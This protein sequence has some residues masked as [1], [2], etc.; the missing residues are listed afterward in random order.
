MQTHHIPADQ[1]WST[2]GDAQ[3]RGKRF[4]EER[5]RWEARAGRPLAGVLLFS[6]QR[7]RALAEHESAIERPGVLEAMVL[8]GMDVRYVFHGERVLTDA[9]LAIRDAYRL[10]SDDDRLAIRE[11]ASA[12]RIAPALRSDLD[13]LIYAGADTISYRRTSEA[14][15]D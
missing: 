13:D 5:A 9:E 15:S 1:P 7:L 8:L 2:A 4:D 12:V 6:K 10:G 11:R 3:A 14:Q